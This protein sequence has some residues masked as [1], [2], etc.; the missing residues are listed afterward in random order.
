MKKKV[1]QAAVELRTSGRKSWRFSSAGEKIMSTRLQNNWGR[2]KSHILL[3][4]IW[5]K[6]KLAWYPMGRGKKG[7]RATIKSSPLHAGG[8][9]R[10]RKA[11]LRGGKQS[12]SPD[13]N[14]DG[15]Y[16][17]KETSCSETGRKSMCSREKVRGAEENR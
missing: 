14:G 8:V 15:S 4:N 3:K 12:A 9:G 1:R 17:R 7:L 5:E 2:K 16:E 6:E 10:G 13:S 11:P